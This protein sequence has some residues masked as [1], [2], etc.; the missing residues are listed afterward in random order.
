MFYEHYDE[1]FLQKCNAM[2]GNCCSMI[3]ISKT[4]D[5]PMPLVKP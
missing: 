2:A 4:E 5:N 1:I 3:N